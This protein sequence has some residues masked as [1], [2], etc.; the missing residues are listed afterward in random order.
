MYEK[1]RRRAT[2]D[3]GAQRFETVFGSFVLKFCDTNT[4]DN[5]FGNFR[6]ITTKYRGT[7]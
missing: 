4:L 2:L 5:Y 7:I 6:R 1:R 3:A